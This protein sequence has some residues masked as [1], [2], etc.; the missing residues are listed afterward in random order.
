MS[1]KEIFLI[2]G[3]GNN[4]F[5]LNKAY[6][7]QENGFDVEINIFLLSDNFI[8]KF[9][10]WTNHDSE[11]IKAL[12][13]DFKVNYSISFVNIL[14][15]IC[16]FLSHRFKIS[17]IQ[18]FSCM[19]HFKTE[20]GYYQKGVEINSLFRSHV[21]AL[22][23]KFKLSLSTNEGADVVVHARLGDFPPPDRLD[24]GYYIRAIRELSE[25]KVTVVTDTPS[26]VL[27]LSSACK[28]EG[29]KVEILQSCGTSALDD[30]LILRQAKKLVISNSTFCYWASQFSD[31]E[32]FYPSY[33]K[34][35]V[36]WYFPI[37]NN[38]QHCVPSFQNDAN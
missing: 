31:A 27:Q 26:F 13:P 17:D 15:F 7:L 38:I 35:G 3:L 29:L 5:Q 14:P 11:I 10:R 21:T 24:M 20:V 37:H 9:L 33:R 1:K 8:T 23:R 19:S 22:F 25:S 2:G 36:Q 12:L 30:F 4:L 28:S 32:V 34:P 16:I 6:V 18:N